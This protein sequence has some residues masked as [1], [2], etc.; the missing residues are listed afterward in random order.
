MSPDNKIVS[1]GYNG[2]PVG[3]SDD[4]LPWTKDLEDVLQNKRFYGTSQAL[5]VF[6][7]YF[8]IFSLSCGTECR[9]E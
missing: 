8:S 2:M 5:I 3:L 9:I 4:D 6:M 1:V 7:F